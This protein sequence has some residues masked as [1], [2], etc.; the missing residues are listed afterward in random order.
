[1]LLFLEK[2]PKDTIEVLLYVSVECIC[3]VKINHYFELKTNSETTVTMLFYKTMDFLGDSVP[4]LP[5]S[6]Y[7]FKV[8]LRS[9]SRQV[10]LSSFIRKQAACSVELG[11]K[12][13][14]LWLSESHW[15]EY[16]IHSADLKS[17]PVVITALSD[18][19]HS[20]QHTG[21]PYVLH[22]KINRKSLLT[23]LWGWPIRSLMTPVLFWLYY[24]Q[25]ENFAF[26]LYMKSWHVGI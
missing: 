24:N 11:T 9:L 22:I 18:R 19:D 6:T 13:Y 3:K 4:R 16:R 10:F 21:C 14:Q 15:V 8:P 20:Y 12:R 25:L 5:F 23:G 1:M 2:N 7:L 17:Q 26:E